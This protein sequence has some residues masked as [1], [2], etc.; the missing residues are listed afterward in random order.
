[1]VMF[2]TDDDLSTF[3]WVE[4]PAGTTVHCEA[5]PDAVL[6]IFGEHERATLKLSP[7]MVG[8]TITALATANGV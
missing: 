4:V 6:L 1:M 8:R 7:T 3:T 2:R 5:E